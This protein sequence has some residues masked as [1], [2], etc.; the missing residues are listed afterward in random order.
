MAD[1]AGFTVKEMLIR[2]DTKVDIV[3]ADHEARLRAL[4][5][6]ANESSAND[7]S[8]EKLSAKRVSW[9]AITAAL[10]G[11]VVQI[12]TNWPHK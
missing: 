12:I 2:L 8:S 9:A 7:V 5:K 1:D 4:E 10:G 6:E 3:L 11:W